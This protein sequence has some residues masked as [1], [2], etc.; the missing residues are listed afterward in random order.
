M[1]NSDAYFAIGFTA[2][3]LFTVFFIMPVAEMIFKV[4][5]R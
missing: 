3:I 4:A 2:G 1:T 5:L